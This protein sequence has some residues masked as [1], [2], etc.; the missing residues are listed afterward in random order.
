[1]IRITDKYQALNKN[2]HKIIQLFCFTFKKSNKILNIKIGWM[3]LVLIV[4][5]KIEY[6]LRVLSV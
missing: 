2:T 6:I 4:G 1:M 5:T 3:F